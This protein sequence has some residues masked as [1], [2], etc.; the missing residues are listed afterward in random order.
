MELVK[1]PTLKELLPKLQNESWESIVSLFAEI[2]KALEDLH[3]EK[4]VHRDLKPGNVFVDAESY[5]NSTGDKQWKVKLA[6][7][8]LSGEFDEAS[9]MATSYRAAGTAYYMA[10]EQRKG[11][12]W[13][14]ASDIYSF[15]IMFYEALTGDIP[16]GAYEPASTQ[17]I[18]LPS[19]FDQLLTKCMTNKPFHRYQSGKA[20]L[21]SFGL[22]SKSKHD[23]RLDNTR[24]RTS[25][26][27]DISNNNLSAT[28]TNE[29]KI[30]KSIHLK[31]DEYKSEYFACV[32][33]LFG[34]CGYIYI[35]QWK[36]SLALWLIL[37]L[38]NFIFS[39]RYIYLNITRFGAFIWLPYLVGYVLV[40]AYDT[41]ACTKKL[42]KT[43]MLRQNEWFP[44]S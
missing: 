38:A 4:V 31:G 21:E 6:D 23:S 17:K 24:I 36:K 1:W 16:Q 14:P 29:Q 37:I 28:K 8:G 18:G 32:L 43:K 33:N 41:F 10:P 7:F 19:Y 25:S 9:K 3:E 26:A 12:H 5:F 30:H 42:N 40:F 44:K 27:P 39:S 34:P 20:L 35:G 15:G 2:A 13:T 11:E 22:P